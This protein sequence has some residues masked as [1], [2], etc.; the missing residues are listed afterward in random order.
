MSIY[1]AILL[2]IV[3]GITEFF[4]VSSSG[5]LILG[6]LIFGVRNLSQFIPFDLVCHLGTLVSIVCFFFR[7]FIQL[8]TFSDRRLFL[9][10]SLAILP[11]FP[12]YFLLRPIKE[13][14]NQPKYLGFFFLTTAL[15][16]FIGEKLRFK[17]KTKPQSFRDSLI[18][19][20]IQAIAILPGVSRSGSTISCASVLG[21]ERKDAARFSFLM[22]LPTIMGGV[23]LEGASMLRHPQELPN[24]PISSYFAG[25]IFSC[26][27]GYL[28]LHFIMKLANKG[29]F[30][31]FMY[32][33][34]AIG[35]FTIVYVNGFSQAA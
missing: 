16:L 15:I 3:Q 26:I 21:W 20:T 12:L 13:I 34:V 11:L 19:G 8:L 32:Y 14:Y 28:A 30:K 4:P 22:A 27:T 5:H 9:R 17:L 35:L 6:E 24:L 23:V 10:L 31:P 18:I 1:E 33:C 7:D 2:G 29:S 25:F